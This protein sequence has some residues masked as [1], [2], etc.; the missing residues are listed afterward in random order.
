M[1]ATLYVTVVTVTTAFLKQRNLKLF[2]HGFTI[3]QSRDYYYYYYYC[4]YQHEDR[5]LD[6]DENA[7]PQEI[8][9]KDVNRLEKNENEN[10]A[11]TLILTS[12]AA[13]AAAD[14]HPDNIKNNQ[15][16]GTA[17]PAVYTVGQNNRTEPS[18][19]ALQGDKS[20]GLRSLDPRKY[21]GWARVCFD[22]GG[23]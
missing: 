22:Q 16:K 14:G 8:R 6:A 17:P 15:E 5:L 23:I 12:L 20:W 2:K 7:S 19:P 21:V 18:F 4:D 11:R 10:A 1:G 3:L 13:A 9:V